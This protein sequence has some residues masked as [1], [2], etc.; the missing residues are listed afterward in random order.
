MPVMGRVMTVPSSSL[1][2]D[3]N[4]FGRDLDDA[5]RLGM[6]NAY[7]ATRELRYLAGVGALE[8]MRVPASL[9]DVQVA[10]VERGL[11]PR[12]LQSKHGNLGAFE[13][14]RRA[15]SLVL[16]ML[17]MLTPDESRAVARRLATD[18]ELCVT[19]RAALLAKGLSVPGRGG[20]LTHSR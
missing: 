20:W 6:F 14:Y 12:I 15:E 4:P 17:P 8:F 7:V 2:R 16:D 1:V 3:G 11:V 5:A 10:Q 13:T 9:L 18:I 19:R